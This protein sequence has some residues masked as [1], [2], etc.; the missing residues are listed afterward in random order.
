[1]DALD[2][3]LVVREGRLVRLGRETPVESVPPP[4]PAP[5][6]AMARASTRAFLPTP[7]ATRWN[8]VSIYRVNQR[9]VRIDCGGRSH[10]RS[11]LDLGMAHG[12]SREPTR[13]WELLV[14][15]CEGHGYLQTSRFGNSDATKAMTRLETIGAWLASNPGCPRMC[16]ARRG[17][18]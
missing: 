6:R 7:A 4:S 17:R 10:R 13:V 15:F 14:T 5:A 16:G 18:R 3:V 12:A 2:E 11:Y 8:L 1:V 9:T